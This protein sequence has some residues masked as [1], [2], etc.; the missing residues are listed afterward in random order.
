MN[1]HIITFFLFQ[2]S[3]SNPPRVSPSHLHPL[4]PGDGGEDE[5]DGNAISFAG[6]FASLGD[7]AFDSRYLSPQRLMAE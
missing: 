3:F 2:R 5:K 1:Q 7:Q 6:L 4:S